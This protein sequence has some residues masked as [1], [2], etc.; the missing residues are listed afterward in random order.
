MQQRDQT[1]PDLVTALFSEN[2]NERD[3]RDSRSRFR[4]CHVTQ[5]QPHE[6]RPCNKGR[7][8]RASPTGSSY[9]SYSCLSYT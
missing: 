5:F 4:S 9:L 2:G 8:Y 7:D 6:L 3:I 1:E